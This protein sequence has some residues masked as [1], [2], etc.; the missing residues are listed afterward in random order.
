MHGRPGSA[1]GKGLGERGV[2]AVMRVIYP[3]QVVQILGEPGSMLSRAIFGF[4]S[5]IQQP[6]TG[7]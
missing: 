3:P 5:S 1:A 7:A 6:G 4:S 2:E